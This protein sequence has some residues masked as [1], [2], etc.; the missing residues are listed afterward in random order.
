MFYLAEPSVEAGVQRINS[1][2]KRG[3]LFKLAFR[4]RKEFPVEL[5]L[6]GDALSHHRPTDRALKRWKFVQP[7][8]KPDRDLFALQCFLKEDQ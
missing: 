7:S 1:V 2:P 8:G 3:T 4:W 6:N 5:L